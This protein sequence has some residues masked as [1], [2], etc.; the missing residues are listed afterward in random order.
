MYSTNYLNPQ[1]KNSALLWDDQSLRKDNGACEF[2][3]LRWFGQSSRSISWAD[4][5][6]LTKAWI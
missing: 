5:K 3:S 4:I 6:G 1:K 2:P